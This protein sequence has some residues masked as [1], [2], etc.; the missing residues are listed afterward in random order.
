MVT[1]RQ[2]AHAPAS[3]CRR[4]ERADAA[5]TAK[6]TEQF[7]TAAATGDLTGLLFLHAPDVTWT[8]DG[9][10]KATAARRLVVGPEKVAAVLVDLF[11]RRRRTSDLRIE[12]TSC[13][14][15]LAIVAY[16]G[17]RLEGVFLV[18]IAG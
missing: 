14:N 3:T 13:N 15:S 7:M 18:E 6:I 2:V 4:F 5:T 17:D 12:M 9:G 10:G 11:Y 8:A 1:V 16:R